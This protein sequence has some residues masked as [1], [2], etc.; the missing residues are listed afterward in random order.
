[1]Q[2]MLESLLTHLSI[3]IETLY[4]RHRQLNEDVFEIQSSDITSYLLLNTIT[5]AGASL[6]HSI[7]YRA[8]HPEFVFDKLSAL[9]GGLLAFSRRYGID[10][11]PGYE[12]RMPPPASCS[13]MR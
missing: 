2:A 8:H 11:F 6:A 9:A 4:G 1:M 3:K 10:T 5:S 7:R 12:Q 13:S